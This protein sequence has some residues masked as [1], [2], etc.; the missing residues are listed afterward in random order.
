MPRVSEVVPRRVAHAEAASAHAEA[1]CQG[2]VFF[3]VRNLF[4]RGS[5]K[6]IIRTND[7]RTAS[8]EGVEQHI[9][10]N[11]PSVESVQISIIIFNGLHAQLRSPFGGAEI[12]GWC[13]WLRRRGMKTWGPHRRC[14][15]GVSK[16]LQVVPTPPVQVSILKPRKTPRKISSSGK[17]SAHVAQGSDLSLLLRRLNQPTSACHF[18][19]RSYLGA[20]PASL[21]LLQV[22]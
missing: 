4:L 3:V 20:P 7:A 9:R 11:S 17:R 1:A 8:A 18:A 15:T 10:L 16:D 2:L 14:S 22:Y 19:D 12:L 21:V 13:R 6:N 5:G